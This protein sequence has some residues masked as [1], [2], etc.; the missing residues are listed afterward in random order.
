MNLVIL[1]LV[2]WLFY[3]IKDEKTYF[4]SFGVKHIPKK[5]VKY[6]KVMKDFKAYVLEHKHLIRSLYPYYR[7]KFSSFFQLLSHNNTINYFSNNNPSGFIPLFPFPFFTLGNA[8]VKLLLS[9]RRNESSKE[10]K[11]VRLSSLSY[12]A[13]LS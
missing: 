11:N 3:V 4:E 8:F 2:R 13:G 7:Y 5:I 6:I 9:T 10:F 1:E 12:L